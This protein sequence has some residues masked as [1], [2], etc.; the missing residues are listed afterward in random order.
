MTLHDMDNHLHALKSLVN[1]E[2]LS[3]NM[4]GQLFAKISC[5]YILLSCRTFSKKNYIPL[6]LKK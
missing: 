2:N 3:V 4:T 1:E 6:P 5:E